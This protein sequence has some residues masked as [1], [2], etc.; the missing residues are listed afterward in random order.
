MMQRLADWFRGNR[1]L[2]EIEYNHATGDTVHRVARF[3]CR[4]F[5]RWYDLWMGVYVDREKR[6]FYVC[7]LP[8][9]GFKIGWF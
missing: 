1:I 8:C 5:F 7:Y 2:G 4:P 9:C 3:R 6:H